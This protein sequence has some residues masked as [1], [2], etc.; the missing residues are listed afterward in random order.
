MSKPEEPR[1]LHDNKDEKI[2]HKDEKTPHKDDLTKMKRLL[3]LIVAH[4]G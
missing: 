3:T 2:P 1:G 4:Q